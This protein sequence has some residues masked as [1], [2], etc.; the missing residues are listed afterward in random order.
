MA[1]QSLIFD[2]YL[3]YLT[4]S[5]NAERYLLDVKYTSWHHLD[6]YWRV[7]HQCPDLLTEVKKRRLP[8][9]HLKRSNLL[10]LYCS[11]KL[12]EQ[13]GVWRSFEDN[14]SADR[15]LTIDV[16]RCIRELDDMR[17]M[18]RLFDRWLFGYP[19]RVLE[20]E[21]LLDADGFS[22]KVEDTFAAIYG[23]APLQPLST[24]HR[25]VTPP[26]REVVVNKD[27]VLSALAGTDFQAMAEAVLS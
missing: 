14:A 1:H 11:Q 16:S 4:R 20:Y 12:A 7:F 5:E 9:V 15:R 26:L 2:E 24:L 25:K 3:S 23:I 6:S 19:V 8:L 17:S 21:T 22:K 18:Q 13:T 10:A 27:E